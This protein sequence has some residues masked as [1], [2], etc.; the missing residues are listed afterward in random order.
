MKKFKA[1]MAAAM[2]A[3]A[4]FTLTS[5]EDLGVGKDYFFGNWDSGF[6]SVDATTGEPY[7]V[8]NED[9]EEVP[10]VKAGS[11]SY[12]IQWY[13]NG[14][15]DSV[16]SGGKGTFY[17]IRTK[18][19]KYDES[20]F[21]V[22]LS[23]TNTNEDRKSMMYTGAIA[24]KT[25]YFGTYTTSDNAGETTGRFNL[26]YKYGY[27]L[28]AASSDT[29]YEKRLAELIEM[30]TTQGKS[31][32]N[33]AAKFMAEMINDEAK[34]IELINADIK[35][36]ADKIEAVPKDAEGNPCYTKK[37]LVSLLKYEPL[38]AKSNI[39]HKESTGQYTGMYSK[40]DYT[41]YV[42]L[43]REEKDDGFKYG[44]E[45][46]GDVESFAYEFGDADFTGYR[47]LTATSTPNAYT[48]KNGKEVKGDEKCVT[49]NEWAEDDSAYYKSKG[50]TWSEYKGKNATRIL[51]WKKSAKKGE[52]LDDLDI[53]GLDQ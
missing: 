23:D 51:K 34:I 21:V 13:F 18:V 41:L 52:A 44:K 46:C 4:V 12:R 33:G 47:K 15:G 37:N 29:E 53:S 43:D 26:S 7:M 22:D 45:L 39:E 25:F 11:E 42:Q 27:N 3:A 5:C 35:N 36:E 40:G 1:F 9:G 50:C 24:G 14:K 48:D 49:I 31:S 30:A 38:Y 20:K 17:Q 32:G 10:G 6:Y 19:A 8:E 28:G 16:F 2:A